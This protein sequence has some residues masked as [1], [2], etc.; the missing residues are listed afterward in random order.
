MTGASQLNAWPIIV[1]KLGPPG[2]FLAPRWGV[3]NVVKFTGLTRSKNPRSYSSPMAY[4]A[5]SPPKEC[6]TKEMYLTL[7]PYFSRSSEVNSSTCVCVWV[8]A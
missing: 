2:T 5:T 4:L 3:T 7:T 6:P 8:S 1:P